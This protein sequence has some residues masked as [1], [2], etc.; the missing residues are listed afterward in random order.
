MLLRKPSQNMD[1]LERIISQLIMDMKDDRHDGYTKE[2]YR[3]RLEQLK[4]Q[5]EKALE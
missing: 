2:Y 5:I 1:Q 4:K 3:K